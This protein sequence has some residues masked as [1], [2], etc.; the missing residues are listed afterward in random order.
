M[1]PVF[2]PYIGADT[3]KAAVDALE[4]G[5][6]G[7][8]SYVAAFEKELG[9]FLELPDQ[10]RIVTVNTCTSALHL[11]LLAAGVGPGDEVIT[12]ALN[13]IGDFQAIG[14]C[15]AHPVFC[16][17]KQENLGLDPSKLEPLI[18]PKVKAIIALHYSGIPCDIS[19]ILAIAKRYNLRVIE[20]A[21]HAVGTRVSGK[22]IGSYGDLVC[23]SFDAIKTLTC[24]DGG[25]VAVNSQLE[26]DY[27]YQARLLGMSQSNDVLYSNSRAYGFDVFK[28]GYRY[29]MANLHANIGLSQLA[30]LNTFIANR[31]KYSRKYNQLLRGVNGI[32]LPKTDYENISTFNYV[33]RVLDEQRQRL[34]VFLKERGVDTGIHWAPGNTFT[35]L[36]NCRGA[37]ML[38]VTDEIGKQILTLPLWSFMDDEIIENVCQEIRGFY[39]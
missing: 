32:V 31:Q 10:R 5:W 39:K 8:G 19:D 17:I 14:M 11:A 26:A 13:N 28:Q 30:K 1:I 25:A 16:D 27:L 20:D 7:M 9:N 29:H 38:P 15:G 34:R 2:K 3:C 12:P 37:D 33:I 23:F 6:L 36:R 18:G 22:M 24:I 4:L 21:A 35:L